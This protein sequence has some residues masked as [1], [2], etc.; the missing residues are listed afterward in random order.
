M[1]AEI[2][3]VRPAILRRETRNRLDE[4]RGFCHIVR[5]VYPFLL[6]PARLRE[7]VDGLPACLASFR[8]D[9]ERFL[10]FLHRVAGQL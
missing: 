2:Q 9:L 7:L 8:E 1:S 6:R 10:A 4:Y 5:N 3:D